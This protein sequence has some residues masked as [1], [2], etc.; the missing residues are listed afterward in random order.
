MQTRHV[1]FVIVPKNQLPFQAHTDIYTYTNSKRKDKN[2]EGYNLM[3]KLLKSKLI[4]DNF[5]SPFK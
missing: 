5:L 4:D 1:V 3:K 2:V